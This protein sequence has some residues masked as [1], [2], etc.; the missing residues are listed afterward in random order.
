MNILG[1]S[2]SSESPHQLSIKLIHWPAPR[3]HLSMEVACLLYQPYS[4]S[5][6]SPIILSSPGF[7]FPSTG[8]LRLSSLNSQWRWKRAL[9]SVSV[10]WVG[11][12]TLEVLSDYCSQVSSSIDQWWLMFRSESVWI[13][14]QDT[15]CMGQTSLNIYF[16]HSDTRS[17]EKW[18]FRCGY[19]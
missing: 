4:L 15:S 9:P 2:L 14:F 13:L 7:L 19:T 8:G 6:Q 16:P 5:L 1:F 10:G 12:D 11:V 18:L 3:T 17:T